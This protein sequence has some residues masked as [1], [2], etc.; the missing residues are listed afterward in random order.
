MN[1]QTPETS[2]I[3]QDETPPIITLV[4][5]AIK[6]DLPVHRPQLSGSRDNLLLEQPSDYYIHF[7][8]DPHATP[9]VYSVQIPIRTNIDGQNV[10]S[11][12]VS[13]SEL[14]TNVTVRGTRPAHQADVLNQF[15]THA[16]YNNMG[17][18]ILADSILPENKNFPIG[19]I[20]PNK[21]VKETMTR[22]IEG[23]IDQI[24][25]WLNT[26]HIANSE[27]GLSLPDQ[28]NG[29]RST[30]YISGDQQLLE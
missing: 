19:K 28:T 13:Q 9:P 30:I 8:A 4:Q 21:V 27:L 24:P 1:N 6:A 25:N 20:D 12:E 3:P 10:T 26:T 16:M 14:G 18:N 2:L 23:G 22:L 7:L 29:N 5:K 17:E 11:Y 15:T